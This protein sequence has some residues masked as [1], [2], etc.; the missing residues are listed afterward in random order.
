V[1]TETRTVT[2][3]SV[4]RQHAPASSQRKWVRYSLMDAEDK[5]VGSTFD[6][7]IGEALDG[8]GGQ[9]VEVDLEVKDGDRGAKLYDLKA[10]RLAPSGGASGSAPTPAERDTRITR[11]VALKAA[12][13]Y[14][15]HWA[16]SR[17]TQAQVLGIADA[18]DSWLRGE[19]KGD[20]GEVPF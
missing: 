16:D 11:S 3:G 8:F 4:A 14:A 20:D 2:V 9:T 17:L 13:D 7:A 12:V 10:V 18:F 15:G 19:E 1:S 5:F 6:K